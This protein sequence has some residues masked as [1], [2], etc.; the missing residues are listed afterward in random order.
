[1][2]REFLDKKIFNS[3]AIKVLLIMRVLEHRRQRPDSPELILYFLDLREEG[4]IS[5]K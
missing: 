4:G 1:M 5:F 3:E 2:T